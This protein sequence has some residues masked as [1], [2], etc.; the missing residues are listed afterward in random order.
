MTL[1][2]LL[3]PDN[4]GAFLLGIFFLAGAFKYA[5]DI[6]SHFKNNGKSTYRRQA[7]EDARK[8]FEVARDNQDMLIRLGVVAENCVKLHER[9]YTLMETHQKDEE[10]ILDAM[11]HEMTLVNERL[12]TI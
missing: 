10:K 6:W 5:L 7:D 11:R 9:Q 4:F 3:R 12:R 2:D 1:P 8:F